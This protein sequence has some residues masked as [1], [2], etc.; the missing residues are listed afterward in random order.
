MLDHNPFHAWGQVYSLLLELNLLTGFVNH[1]IDQHQVCL[2]EGGREKKGEIW[3]IKEVERCLQREK[4]QGE[5]ELETR[6]KEKR[7]QKSEEVEKTLNVVRQSL[8]KY[9]E[10][11]YLNST[12]QHSSFFLS[13][14]G[15]GRRLAKGR[16]KVAGGTYFKRVERSSFFLRL[17]STFNPLIFSYKSVFFFFIKVLE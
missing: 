3:P 6:G 13:P 2:T 10:N 8:G 4:L 1:A 7:K 11:T 17:S 5:N 12:F 16:R 15:K 9:E 14:L